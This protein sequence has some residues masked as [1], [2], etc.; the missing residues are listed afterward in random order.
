MLWSPETAGLA[1]PAILFL[2]LLLD[3]LVG[4]FGPLF[5]IL[6]HPVALMGGL[7]GWFDRRLNREQRS[8]RTRVFRGS[9]VTL[10][11]VGLAAVSGWFVLEVARRVPQGWIIE[12]IAVS[13]L[14]AQRSLFDHVRAV[15]RGLDK[16]G[17][18]GGRAAVAM[19]VGRDPE[20]LDDHGVSRAAIESLAESFSDGVVAPVFWYLLFGLPGLLVYKAVN[21][22]DSM[23]GYRTPR[24]D[25][26]GRT[27]A[28]LDDVMNYV[29]ARIAAALIVLASVFVPRGRPASAFRV[30]A[31][32]GGQHRSPN[33]GWPEAAMAG[34][35]G[36]ALSGPRSYQGKMTAQPWV[37]GEFSAQIG[38]GEIRR[39][40]YLFVVACL[41]EAVIVALL[42]SM[43]LAGGF[44]FG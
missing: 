5:R 3:A 1:P 41:L 7:I 16:H 13:L 14:I 44:S 23:I 33:A 29:P 8:A 28:R 20:T 24:H 10:L 43:T 40:L 26:F 32:D 15:A 34:A 2:A 11:M 18:A 30:M 19:I 31:R 38:T 17:L 9:M 4:E 27:A 6:P 36:V 25:A 21:T 39:G 37:G 35:L 12:V 42:A 22:M